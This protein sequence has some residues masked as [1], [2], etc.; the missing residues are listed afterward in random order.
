MV[1]RSGI[2]SLGAESVDLSSTQWPAF[3]VNL[4]MFSLGSITSGWVLS[5]RD[6]PQLEVCVIRGAG[7]IKE[8]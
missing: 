2:V 7:A 8:E 5:L 6:S 3:A 1:L 4:C